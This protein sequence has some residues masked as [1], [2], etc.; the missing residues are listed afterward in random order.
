MTERAARRV[1][2]AL[3]PDDA[4]REALAEAAAQAARRC[5][6]RRMR[7]DGLH[8]TLAFIGAVTPAQ[9]D[10]PQALTG[11]V[12]EAP[13]PLQ[14][15]R[16]GFWQHNR[17]V[18]A[19]CHQTPSGQRRLVEA[20]ATGLAAAGFTLD[21]RPHVPHVTLLRNA[22]CVGPLDEL[23]PVRWSVEAFTLVESLLQPDGARYRVLARWPLVEP[24]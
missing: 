11:E 15:D 3:W 2:F 9:L 23:A 6:G 21:G 17:I 22:R 5:G 19:G 4:A 1:F 12:R 7:A 20:L 10:M 13:Y 8:L 24:A 16:L 18:W 14:L